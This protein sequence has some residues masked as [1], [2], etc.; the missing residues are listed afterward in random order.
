MYCYPIDCCPNIIYYFGMKLKTCFADMLMFT[1]AK[2]KKNDTLKISNLYFIVCVFN[3]LQCMGLGA[4]LDNC[5]CFLLPE[6]YL[7]HRLNNY[8]YCLSMTWY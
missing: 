7:T 8:C 3:V 4:A 5:L 2:V 6:E 1:V